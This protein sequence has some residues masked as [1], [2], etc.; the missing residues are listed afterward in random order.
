V[1]VALA[2]PQLLGL[3]SHDATVIA[4]GVLLLRLS[5]IYE[6]GRVFNIVIIN[7]LRATG[8]ARFPIQI[9]MCSQWFLSVPL[10]W[11]VGVRFHWGLPGIWVVMMTEEW[12]RGLIMYRRWTRRDWLKYAHHSRDQVN[13]NTLPLVPEG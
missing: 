3:F 7:A 11:L 6:P 13:G 2:A 9:A 8:D 5:V 4:G 1:L 10:C 12:A